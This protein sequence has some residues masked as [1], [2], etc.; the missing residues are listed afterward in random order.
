[1][2][3]HWHLTRFEKNVNNHIRGILESIKYPAFEKRSDL[4]ASDGQYSYMNTAGIGPCL[5]TAQKETFRYSE[6]LTGLGLLS[7]EGL[8][9]YY[10]APGVFKEYISRIIKCKP[11]E[12]TF[13]QNSSQAINAVLGSLDLTSKDVILTSDQEHP[14][15]YLPLKN[16]SERF[17]TTVYFVPYKK[18]MSFLNSFESIYKLSKDKIKLVFLSLASYSSGNI[19]PVNEILSMIDRSKTLVYV[20]AAQYAGLHSIDLSGMKVDF[21]AFRATSGITG[22]WEQACSMSVKG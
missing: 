17:G 4:S 3:K 11:S 16:L 1:M 9:H 6:F 22:P 12:I 10:T 8:A 20:D 18:P 14:S 7:G 15:G 5:K 13:F 2:R 21:L 19:L